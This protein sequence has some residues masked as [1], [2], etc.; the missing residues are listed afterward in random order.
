[1]RG[2]VVERGRQPNK[3]TS[4]SAKRQDHGTVPRSDSAGVVQLLDSSSSGSSAAQ[5][6]RPGA[7]GVARGPAELYTPRPVI[8]CYTPRA[9]VFQCYYIAAQSMEY[10]HRMH[11]AS[12]SDALTGLSSAQ[13]RR[14]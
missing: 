6:W 12:Y 14:H 8:T 4:R 10:R 3:A 7:N 9:R 11:P 13:L 1:M 5:A 2:R